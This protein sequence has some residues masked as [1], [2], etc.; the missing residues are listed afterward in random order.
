MKFVDAHI[1]LSDMEYS[2]KIAAV[3]EEAKQFNVIAL[4]SNSMN[5][6]TS[7]R[8]LRLAEENKGFVYAAL[9]VHP[10]NIRNLGPDELQQTLNLISQ[11]KTNRELVVAV[12]EIGLDPQYAKRKELR[13]LQVKVFTDMLQA[14]EKSALPVIVHSRWS[15]PRIMNI[16]S[17]YNLKAVLF[18]WFSSPLELLPQMIE[19]GYYISEGPPTV[20]SSRTQD[21]IRQV[22]ITNLLTET[23]GPV[24]YFGPFKDRLTTPAFIPH[25]VKAMAE[26]KGMNEND[27]AEQVVKNFINFF[28]IEKL[29]F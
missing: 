21:V 18:H 14:A 3:L 24:H 13:E 20:F 8:S 19:R 28:R 1:H 15:A 6:E 4:V 26:I 29:E 10:W 12:G 22:P 9:G 25:V 11:H 17:S 23:D 27:V 7:L 2:N 5:H 16:L